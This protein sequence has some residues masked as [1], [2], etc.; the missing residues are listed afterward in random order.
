MKSIRNIALAA[1]AVI[2]SSCM[3]N[4]DD[5]PTMPLPPYGNNN[6]NEENII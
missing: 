4:Y 5:E 6:I 1:V 2:L 3:G